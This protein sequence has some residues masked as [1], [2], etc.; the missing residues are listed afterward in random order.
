MTKNEAAKIAYDEL[1]K[2]MSIKD[3]EEREEAYIFL[4]ESPDP[5]IIPSKLIAAVNKKT[6]KTGFSIL[7][8]EDAVKGC[9]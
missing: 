1:D 8:I 4:C 2:T 7:S 9:K 3:I 6:G 5:N